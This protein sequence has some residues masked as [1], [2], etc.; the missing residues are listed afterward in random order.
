MR[1]RRD[2]M[3][4]V[5]VLLTLAVVALVVR[6]AGGG[7]GDDPR[8][9]S[10]LTG[11]NGAAA[12]YMLMDELDIPA[13]RLLRTWSAD[14]S[15]DALVLLAPSQPAT[16]RDVQALRDWIEDGGTLLYGAGGAGGSAGIDAMLGL[17]LR[18]TLPDTL[19]PLATVRWEG[20]AAFPAPHALA[21]DIDSISG[22]TLVFRGD[23]KALTHASTEVLMR[24]ADGDAAVVTLAVGSGRVIAWSDAAVLGNGSL[25][26]GGAVL[27]ARAAR[28]V[29]ADGGT[30]RFD[31]YHHGYREAK[32]LRALA[33]VLTGTGGGRALLQC[34]VACLALL[35]LA[36]ARFGAPVE[37]HTERRRSPIEHMQALAGAYER[38][39]AR[40]AAR[41]LLLAGME[42][43]L[44][45]RVIGGRAV[46]PPAALDGTAAGR[47][48][49][50]EWER[51]VE[52]DLTD[53]A[54]A[55]DEF[56]TE[57]R[58]WK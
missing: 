33:A 49:K 21:A 53:L 47:R 44:G 55:I 14:S 1:N 54:A 37:E 16:P 13:R 35:L 41:R 11:S 28:A 32:P 52:G 22:F 43:Q 4:L 29:T 51:G 24:T 25:R 48:L 9:S 45:R 19:G 12:L 42:R 26:D 2:V 57:V 17:E 23:S 27:F 10:F 31:E 5:G 56:V 36:G 8:V 18:R 50:Q 7:D 58:R 34:L 39:D 15:R 40:G 3:V 38:S 46:L 30:L 20:V 6:P